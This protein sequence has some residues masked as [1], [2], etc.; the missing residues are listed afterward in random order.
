MIGKSLASPTNMGARY[1]PN[2]SHGETKESKDNSIMK[3]MLVN[4]FLL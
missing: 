3:E 1:S 4:K 2:I